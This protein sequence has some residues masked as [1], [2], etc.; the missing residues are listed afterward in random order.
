MMFCL[1]CGKEIPETAQY[2]TFCGQKVNQNAPKIKQGTTSTAGGNSNS[3]IRPNNKPSK[4]GMSIWTICLIAAAVLT[5]VALLINGARIVGGG[6]NGNNNPFQPL[7]GPSQEE[8]DA[9]MYNGQFDEYSGYDDYTY[10]GKD[11]VSEEYCE[12][13]YDTFTHYEF[14]D[15]TEHIALPFNYNNYSEQW[16]SYS[17][18]Y[19]SR[20]V[21]WHIGDGTWY[22]EETQM[23][24]KNAYMII[25]QTGSNQI[26]IK[27]ND[28]ISGDV[29]LDD[30]ITLG[31]YGA[32]FDLYIPGEEWGR[33]VK[34][35]YNV[36]IDWD[37]I[38]INWGS[39]YCSYYR[40]N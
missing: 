34:Y 19:I 5:I 1:R 8:A 12:Y 24:I 28:S 2:C 25:D 33:E 30:V 17:T 40:N 16:E 13:Y 15:V 4:P 18:N 27:I 38:Y 10:T 21:T 14:S 11:N 31:E 20:D 36:H 39:A 37:S 3:N 6:N 29:Y 32:D 7:K 23:R 35:K 26:H 9:I 22:P